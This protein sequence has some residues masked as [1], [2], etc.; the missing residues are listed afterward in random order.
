MFSQVCVKNSVWGG[1]PHC[2]LGY[3][4]PTGHIPSRHTHT[5]WTHT[6]FGIQP[7]SEMATVADGTH[8]SGM[9]SCFKTNVW[10]PLILLF[11]TSGDMRFT[12]GVEFAKLL[13]ASMAAKLFSS[14]YLSAVIDGA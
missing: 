9:H 1:L 13:A 4:H 7:L 3:T 14:T 10:G 12:S 5:P 8:T 2:M 6:P 11:W